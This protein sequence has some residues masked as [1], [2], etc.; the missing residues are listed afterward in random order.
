MH[1]LLLMLVRE[2]HETVLLRDNGG[3]SVLL[4]SGSVVFFWVHGAHRKTVKTRVREGITR[5]LLH[6]IRKVFTQLRRHFFENSIGLTVSHS[7]V[8][9]VQT[10]SNILQKPN[11]AHE[12]DRLGTRRHR[13]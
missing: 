5:C 7:N 12:I 10:V 9:F 8:V 1:K 3:S 6:F 4:C 2:F 13:P 11:S